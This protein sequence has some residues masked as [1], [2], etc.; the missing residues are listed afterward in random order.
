[1]SN[2]SELPKLPRFKSNYYWVPLSE[3]S[4]QLRSIENIY[5]L[6][7]ESVTNLVPRVVPLLDGTRTLD[8]LYKSLPDVNPEVID[9]LIIRFSQFFFIEDA[10]AENASS[11]TSEEIE[12][13]Q[14]QLEY[15]SLFSE[16]YLPDGEIVSKYR[17]FETLKNSSCL[18]IG[19]GNVGMYVVASLA[20]A[21]IGTIL[22]YDTSNVMPNNIGVFCEKKDLGTKRSTIAESIAKKAN[23][24]INFKSNSNNSEAELIELICESD[25]VILA[26]DVTL[27]SEYTRINEM[28]INENKTWLSV[29]VAETEVEVG[30]M[31]VPKQ[32]PCFTCYSS[33]LNG[34]MSHFDEN[35]AYSNY[36]ESAKGEITFSSIPA[37]YTMAAS[38][39][40]IEIIKKITSIIHPL[41]LSH[42]INYNM[43]TMETKSSS[44]LRIP[45]CESCGNLV[46]SP[47]IAPY[48]VFLS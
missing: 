44:I 12:M 13:N 1:M 8:N 11:L 36:K 46:D 48:S 45:R 38:I 22:G 26:S 7:G 25:L 39:A 31:I 35:K 30:P 2:K 34:N 10:A 14:N 43:I 40:T 20:E 47:S 41:S 21:G 23:P 24:N 19:L 16:R 3:D 17:V 29:R 18:V 4:I 32:T 15:F 6:T 9:S 33:R 28:C 37:M 27:D 42:V 5:I